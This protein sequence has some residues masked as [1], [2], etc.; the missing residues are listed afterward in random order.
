MLRAMLHY[1][2]FQNVCVCVCVRVHVLRNLLVNALVIVNVWAFQ[3]GFLFLSRFYYKC[4]TFSFLRDS[5][6]NRVFCI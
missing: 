4:K 3:S 2:G 5:N 6:V 1:V